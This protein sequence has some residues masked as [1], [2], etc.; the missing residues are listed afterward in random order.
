MLSN[1][2]DLRALDALLRLRHVGR[3]AVELRTSQPAMSRTLARLRLELGDALLVRGRNENHLT[4]RAT[5]ISAGLSEKISELGGLLAPPRFVPARAEARIRVGL[6]DFE[7]IVLL[8]ALVKR[9]RQQAPGIRLDVVGGDGANLRH[10]VDGTLDCSIQSPRT[11]PAGCL[12]TGLFRER[13]VTLHPATMSP[14]DLDGFVACPHVAVG[15]PDDDRSAVD[16]ELERLGRSRVVAAR[17]PYFAVAHRFA[18]ESGL[19]FSGP[20]R[21]IASLPVQKHMKVS[22]LPIPTMDRNFL[23]CLYWHERQ[24]G[25]PMHRWFRGQLRDVARRELRPG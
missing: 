10:V 21:L 19:I 12:R 9:L 3:A 1:L 5:A 17:V 2:N 4:P 6:L 25:D 18:V 16:I 23:V 20:A 8:P 14:L 15:T 7:G 22:P 24:H 13:L 11:A